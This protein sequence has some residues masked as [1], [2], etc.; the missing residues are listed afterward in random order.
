M[1]KITNGKEEEKKEVSLSI[2]GW[3]LILSLIF[4]IAGVFYDTRAGINETRNSI[5]ELKTVKLDT[6]RYDRDRQMD[7]FK[8]SLILSKLNEILKNQRTNK[9]FKIEE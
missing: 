9:N 8:D 2:S 4:S 5:Q 1:L 3:L 6:Y 7:N